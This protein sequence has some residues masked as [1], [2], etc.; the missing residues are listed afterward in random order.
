MLGQDRDRE[1]RRGQGGLS[2]DRV[3]RG[4]AGRGRRRWRREEGR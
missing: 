1:V 2:Q 4:Q 3:L